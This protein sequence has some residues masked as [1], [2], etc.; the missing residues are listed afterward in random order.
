MEKVEAA[1][2][3]FRDV[4]KMFVLCAWM[5]HI[6]QCRGAEI[7]KQCN[8]AASRRATARKLG[9]NICDDFDRDSGLPRDPEFRAQAIGFIDKLLQDKLAREP[10]HGLTEEEAK[11]AK[12]WGWI[13]PGCPY[14]PRL[15]VR[16]RRA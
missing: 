2:G 4:K 12:D 6:L 11:R 5:D 7:M 1:N 13:E 10:H 16:V 9:T 3:G 14:A 15:G 8:T